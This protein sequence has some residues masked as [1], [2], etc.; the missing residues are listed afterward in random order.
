[1]SASPPFS[2][3]ST[4]AFLAAIVNSSGDAILS[5]SLDGIITS[6]NPGAE[7]MFGYTASEAV[8]QHVSILF[9]PDRFDEEP[10]ILEHI[11]RG[12]LVD[13]YET[14]RRRKDGALL[15]ISLTVSPIFDSGGRIV[16]ASKI[17]RNI[18]DLKTAERKLAEYA[19][20][21][22]TKVRE[23]TNRLEESVA[24]LE[25]FSYSLSHDMRAP[26]RA[27]Q[28]LTE[29]VLTDHGPRIPEA[30]PLLQRVAKAAARL[31]R[32]IRDVL[33]FAHLSRTEIHL[34]RVD[35]EELVRE[36][37]RERVEFQPPHA[38]IVVDSPLLAVTAHDASLAQCLS[39]LLDNA[40]KF[41]APGVKP[42][43]RVFTARAGERVRIAVRDN[44]IGIDTEAKRRLFAVFQRLHT[45]QQYP[46]TGIG[47]AIVRRAA[48]R[49]HGS[50]GVES[51]PGLGSTFWIELPAAP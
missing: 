34:A 41:V 49:M 33:N 28:S 12:E 18:T 39:N 43:I 8:G 19:A 42:H 3:P 40:V 1:M 29:I 36:I 23:R 6:W 47:L 37:I 38:E 48:E 5:K 22:E 26:V 30:V 16:G 31:D 24:E 50:V 15:D 27:I 14:V 25:S 35:T 17:A 9:P 44:G 46:G 4:D 32:L 21:L 2:H 13:H 11:R 20:D 45:P 7:R 10:G 51:A